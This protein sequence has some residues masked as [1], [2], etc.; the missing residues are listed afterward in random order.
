MVLINI[1]DNVICL[2]KYINNYIV[3]EQHFNSKYLRIRQ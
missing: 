1:D 3:Y 2:F